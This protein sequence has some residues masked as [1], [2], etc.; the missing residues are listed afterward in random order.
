MNRKILTKAVLGMACI[1]LLASCTA[2]SSGAADDEDTITFNWGRAQGSYL[3]FYVAE[4]RGY[5]TD[6]GLD[7]QMQ[8]FQTGA[9]MLAALESESLDLVTTGLASVFALGKGI[10]LRYISLEG[11]ASA[12]EGFVASAESGIDSLEDLVNSGPIGVA[13]GTCVQVSAYYA[14]QSVGVDLSE[15]DTVDITPN[16]YANAFAG[17]SVAGGFSWSPYLFDLEERGNKIIGFD[18][19][20][21]PG[22]GTCP[23]MHAGRAKF[24]DEHPEVPTKMLHALSRA[25]EDLR[26]EP[27]L[28]SQML[29]KHLSVSASV[30]DKVA[31]RYM[32]VQPTL[33][34]QLDENNR[35]AMVG[36]E[37]LY[38]QIKLASDTFAEMG[39]IEEALSEV[40]LRTAID[41][42]YIEAAEVGAK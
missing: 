21:V 40:Q 26:A 36:E 27:E 10:D 33:A 5:F 22:G 23:E 11:D 19:D 31:D 29:Q 9:P 14:A 12:A 28:G 1:G 39:V 34:E 7:P 13:T 42:Q 15:V 3:A 41:P 16:L 38:A 2:A 32:S 8:V 18:Q 37:G 17:G 20:W 30:G 25:W 6:E 4:E 35:Y 24:L